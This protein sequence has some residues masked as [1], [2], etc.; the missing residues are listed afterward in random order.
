MMMASG[1]KIVAGLILRKIVTPKRETIKVAI[2]GSMY[3]ISP[4]PADR[5]EIFDEAFFCKRYTKRG[6]NSRI[7]NILIY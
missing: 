5:T 2:A 1:L 7:S 6:K 3:F 4:P